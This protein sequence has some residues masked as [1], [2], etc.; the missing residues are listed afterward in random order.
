MTARWLSIAFVV[1]LAPLPGCGSTQQTTPNDTTD[2][3]ASP[4][5]TA[6][7]TGAAGDGPHKYKLGKL[8]LELD[9][10]DGEGL[11]DSPDAVASAPPISSSVPQATGAP[12]VGPKSP[13]TGKG[14]AKPN[15]VGAAQSTSASGQ[16]SRENI[17]ATLGG[18][19]ES[20]GKCVDT[21][22]TF[23]ARLTV[24]PN[25]TVSEARVTKSMPDDPRLR[26]C[27]TEAL[28]R[29][30]FP[31]TNAPVPLSFSLAIEPS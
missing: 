3:T 29:L 20:F 19:E 4:D 1:L 7:P 28:R 24:A 11:L 6:A 26:D 2:S 9:D 21:S 14:E 16:L 22:S 25:G 5:A 13:A 8:E 17:E 31:A 12:I 27:L 18:S 23:S 10:A 30:T 15:A